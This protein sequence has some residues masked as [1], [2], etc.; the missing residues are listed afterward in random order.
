MAIAGKILKNVPVLRKLIETFYAILFAITISA[1]VGLILS[2]PVMLLW[3]YVFGDLYK[4]TVFQAWALN[5]LA[6]IL[7]SQRSSSK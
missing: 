2:L 1:L 5:V 6:G 7:F 4:I 3:N